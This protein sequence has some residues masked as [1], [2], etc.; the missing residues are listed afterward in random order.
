LKTPAARTTDPPLQPDYKVRPAPK[1][2]VM[3]VHHAL[4]LLDGLDI[5]IAWKL[6][7][8]DYCWRVF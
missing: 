3:A 5:A 2:N 4:G 7:E 1:L 8:P 6:L